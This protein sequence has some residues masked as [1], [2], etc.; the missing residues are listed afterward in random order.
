MIEYLKMER[1]EPVMMQYP[2]LLIISNEC[3]SS[4]SS[5]GRTLRNLLIGWPKEKLAQFH[6]RRTA[7]DQSVCD[8]FYYV[9]D[10]AALRAFLTG[11]GALGIHQEDETATAGHQ[12]TAGGRR[13]SLTMMLRDL[14][15]N[16]GRWAGKRFQQWVDE[17]SPEVI[18]LQA[19]DCGFMLRI[20]RKLAEKYHIPLVIY[21]SEGYYFKQFDY[22]QSKGIAKLAYPIFY[23]N[24]CR[25]F[26]RTIRVASKSVYCCDKLKRDYDAY[27]GLPSEVI[28]TATQ[29]IAVANEPQNDPLQISYLGNLGVGRHEGLVDIA[30]ALQHISPELKLDVYGRIPNQTVEDA[31]ERCP[32]ICY[33][34]FV[35]YDEVQNVIR[36]SDILIHT[37]NFSDFYKEDLQYA[38]STKIAD[39]LASGRCFFLYAPGNLA[40]TEYLKNHEAAYVI[41]RKEDLLP[42]LEQLCSDSQ[43]RTKYIENALQLVKENHKAEKNAKHFQDILRESVKDR[44]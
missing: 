17:F 11:K 44:L 5:N 13:N 39:S 9:S 12:K 24:F 6:I 34:G 28:Y 40:C 27:F 2:R 37:E 22:F 3:L 23:R 21:N 16:S 7:P 31:F 20:A 41:E 42:C 29:M 32:G 10:S 30:N 38:F 26:D 33:R 19:G 14:V 43:A 8:R 36:H 35:S 15:W 1:S 18:L 4:V 25:E